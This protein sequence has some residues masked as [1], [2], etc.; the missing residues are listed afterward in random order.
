MKKLCANCGCV[1]ELRSKYCNTC[2]DVVR[3]SQNNKK[4]PNRYYLKRYGMSKEE[5]ERLS[6]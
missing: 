5:Y 3:E 2:R 4:K 1:W 6:N